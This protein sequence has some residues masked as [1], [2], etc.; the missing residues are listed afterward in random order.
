MSVGN[1]LTGAVVFTGIFT[2]KPSS[3]P[4]WAWLGF[5]IML[6]VAGAAVGYIVD[7]SVIAKKIKV[8]YQQWTGKHSKKNYGNQLHSVP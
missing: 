2:V 8:K 7:N 6:I 1:I 5:F 3:I 4:F